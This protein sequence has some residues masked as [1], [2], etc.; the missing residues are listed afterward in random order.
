MYVNMYVCAWV[1]VCVCGKD[2]KLKGYKKENLRDEAI[3]SF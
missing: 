1:C 3:H 2:T